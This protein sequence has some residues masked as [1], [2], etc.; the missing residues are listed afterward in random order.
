[1]TPAQHALWLYWWTHGAG[2]T[3]WQ[4]EQWL[5]RGYGVRRCCYLSDEQATEA[6]PRLR[7]AL[8]A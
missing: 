1:M 4:W 7:E 6:L 5:W 2:W 8:R 3:A